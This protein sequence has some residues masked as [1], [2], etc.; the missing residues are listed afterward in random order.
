[1]AGRYAGRLTIPRYIWYT[2][3]PAVGV[4]PAQEKEPF[5]RDLAGELIAVK[6]PTYYAAA[7]VGKPAG[8]YYVRTR[9]AFRKPMPDGGEEA[10][11]RV[12]KY[13]VTPFSGG[14]LSVFW[15]P[16]YGNALLGANWTPRVHHG[17][18][19]RMPDGRRWWEDYLNHTY[20]LDAD[21]GVLTVTGVIEEQ[22]IE[23]RRVMRFGDDALTMEVTLTASKDVA[24]SGIV[25]IIPFVFGDRKA[26]GVLLNV[27]ER[28][29]EFT[30]H[31]RK[32]NGVRYSFN[33][34][35]AFK[36]VRAM[37]HAKYEHRTGRIEV[38]LPAKLKAGQPVKFAYE[39]RPVS[40]GHGGKE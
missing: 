21:A 14:G 1:M 31:D 11:K 6:R 9:H 13:N 17:L 39:I 5:V 25:E 35:Y 36:P 15:T 27:P 29:K 20:A 32:G 16:E 33:G 40:G 7:Y 37:Y 2:D 23:Y 10:D 24:A 19:V 12:G 18:I 22:P 8:E 30:I 4:F 28:G 26:N 34:E 38:A 3:K